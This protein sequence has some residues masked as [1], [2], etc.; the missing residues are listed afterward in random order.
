MLYKTKADHT[1]SNFYTSKTPSTNFTWSILEYFVPYSG[2]SSIEIFHIPIAPNS[3][4]LFE[5]IFA[6]N[7]SE[8]FIENKYKIII[9]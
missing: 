3:R 7:R 2:D 1:H 4:E 8:C 6:I 5:V 9:F